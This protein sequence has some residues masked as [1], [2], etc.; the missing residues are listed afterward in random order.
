MHGSGIGGSARDQRAGDHNN[1]VAFTRQAA[2]Q[3]QLF[4][5]VIESVGRGDLFN[6]LR[7]HAFAQ[8]QLASGGFVGGQRQDCLLY[9]SDAADE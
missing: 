3:R 7:Y 1:H 8:H 5:E 6:Q 2:L 9:T 4:T